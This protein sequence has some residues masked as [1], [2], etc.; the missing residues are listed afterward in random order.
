MRM[1]R[2]P[3]WPPRDQQVSQSEV[4]LM[5]PLCAGDEARRSTL[6]LKPRED[7]TRSPKQGISGPTKRTDVLQI[8]FFKKKNTFYIYTLLEVQKIRTFQKILIFA[9]QARIGL[10]SSFVRIGSVL[11]RTRSHLELMRPLV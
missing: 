11:V 6:A 4:N 1:A 8:F 7:V 2:L 10:D 5:S 9:L 3:C